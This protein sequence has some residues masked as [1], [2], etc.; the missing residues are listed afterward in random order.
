MKMKRFKN[1]KIRY[2]FTTAVCLP[3]IVFILFLSLNIISS[4]KKIKNGKANTEVSYNIGNYDYFLRDDAT[5]IQRNYFKELEKALSAK[6]IDDN[7]VAE[8]VV[9]NFVADM[10]TWTNKGGSYDVGGVYYL[11][12]PVRTNLYQQ[13]RNRFYKNFSNYEKEFGKENLLE[14][15]NVETTFIDNQKFDGFTDPASKF[16]HI[17]AN[18]VY[19][20]HPNFDESKFTKKGE[21]FLIKNPEGRFE[22]IVGWE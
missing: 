13:A 11:Y 21:F 9:K 2:L 12:S 7:L 19:K 20:D 5:R 3:F 22:I 1:K 10:Y 18:W 15:E 14:V 4:I 16:F 8:L 17:T 6:E